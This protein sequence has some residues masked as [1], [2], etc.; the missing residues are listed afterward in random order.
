M[1]VEDNTP[2]REQTDESLRVERLKAD[3]ELREKQEAIDEAADAIIE[4]ARA[5]ADQVLAAARAKSDLEAKRPPGAVAW[6]PTVKTELVEKER[7]K[8]DQAVQEE[9]AAADGALLAAR[10]TQAAPSAEREETDKDLSRERARSDGA[11]TARDAFLGIVSHDLRNMLGGMIGFASLIAKRV[12]RNDYDERVVAYAE[13]INRTGARM[14]R[15]IG[16]LVDVASIEAG[17]LS[18]NPEVIDPALVLREAVDTFETQAAERRITL[19]A[20]PAPSL[21]LVSLDPA[22]ILQ[23]LVNLITNAIKFTPP[24]GKIVATV[25]RVGEELCFT[26]TDTGEGIPA[27]KL[28]AIFERF[29]QVTENDR[30]GVGLGLYISKCIVHGHRG[31]IWA[32]STPGAGSKFVFT[33][34]IQ[35]TD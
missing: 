21:P 8:E 28:D 26:V 7:E 33:I 27:D 34:P 3:D 29:L 17:V 24:N 25:A 12:S 20:E 11:V 4:Q 19:T 15:L 1:P 18:V 23:V 30:R 6:L 16:D 9:R 35:V 5:R 32:E 22:R 14:N 13:R 10:A 2:E 31:R